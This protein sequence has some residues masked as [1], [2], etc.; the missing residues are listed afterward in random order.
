MA[1]G[2]FCDESAGASLKNVVYFSLSLKAGD[3][4]AK[5][6][7]LIQNMLIYHY[8]ASLSIISILNKCCIWRCHLHTVGHLN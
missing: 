8:F 5:E 2:T 1:R 6:T 4:D 7:Y 3:V